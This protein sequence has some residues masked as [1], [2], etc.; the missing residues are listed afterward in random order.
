MSENVF[1]STTH[2]TRDGNKIGHITL[3]NPT[4]LNALS[5]D[6]VDPMLEQLEKWKSS[7]KIVA[8]II[9]GAG[10][11]AFCAGGDIRQVYE[12]MASGEETLRSKA[13]DYFAREYRLD[14]TLHTYSKPIMVWG[15]GIVMGGGMGLFM[16]GDVRVVT[17]T[18]RMAMPEITIALYPDVGASY[19]LNQIPDH[20][21]DFIALT[22]CHL[23]A[24]DA[25]LL[26]MATTVALNRDFKE[27]LSIMKEQTW[28]GRK[29]E[30][31]EV[32]QDI[33]DTFS[34][35][36]KEKLAESEIV[37]HWETIQE[38]FSE[39]DTTTLLNNFLSLRTK[40]DWLKQAQKNLRAGSPLHAY[41]IH[42][43]LKLNRDKTLEEAFQSE[44]RLS[45]NI[46]RFT[47]FQEGIRALLIDKDRNPKW[48]FT[49]F[50]KVE[51]TF[52]DSFFEEPWETNPLADLN[53]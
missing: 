36:A 27:I 30:D 13:E 50:D 38:I 4:S 47:E 26:E 20:L 14:H 43:Q 32:M 48:H 42:R 22:G 12:A 44:V 3:N 21:G 24:N 8:V 40:N 9:T 37:E 33:V 31:A 28:S 16:G 52:V 5:I 7:K 29:E 41:I 46:V 15:S 51:P 35:D 49:S 23:N 18:T 39:D 11:K 6:M 10:D 17:E 34:A 1:T 53:A 2:F 25:L 19:F 45:T